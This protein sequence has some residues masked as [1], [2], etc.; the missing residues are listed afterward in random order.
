MYASDYGFAASPSAWT[1]KMYDYNDST[2]TSN[3]WM[4]M[5]YTEWTISPSSSNSDNVFFLDFLGHLSTSNANDGFGSRPVFYLKASVA[6]AGGSGT[7][8]SPITLTV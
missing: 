5:G 2:A 7:K 4:Y 6:Y 1:L 3:N 8:D